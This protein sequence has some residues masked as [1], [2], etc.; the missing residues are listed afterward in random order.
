MSKEEL[1]GIA[2]GYLATLVQSDATAMIRLIGAHSVIE[3]PR[4]PGNKGES[5]IRKFVTNFQS[6]IAGMSPEIEHLRTAAIRIY[7]DVE[8]TF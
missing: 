4:F 6:W 5:Q 2:E 1:T 3:D 8:F 7:D